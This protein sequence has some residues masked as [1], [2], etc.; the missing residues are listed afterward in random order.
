L[1]LLAFV[2]SLLCWAVSPAA[3]AESVFV[4]YRG[5]VELSPFAC[6]DV[7]R[8]SLV[9]RVCYDAAHEYMLISLKSTYSHYCR[10]DRAT[11]DSLLAAESMGRFYN[12]HIKGNFDCRQGGVPTY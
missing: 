6:Q 11:V 3:H 12:A 10:I 9:N 2:A 4:K 7:T 8:S 5:Q 1:H